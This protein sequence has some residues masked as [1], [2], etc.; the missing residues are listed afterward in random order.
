MTPGR[1]PSTST[2]ACSAEC[3][4]L[5][6]PVAVRG[7]VPGPLAGVDGC[8]EPGIVAHRVATGGDL[9]HVG[10]EG[11]QQRGRGGPGRQML[12]SSTRKPERSAV[13]AVI[14][15]R[16]L[17]SRPRLTLSG[18]GFLL[19]HRGHGS[20]GP[21]GLQRLAS[22]RPSARAVHDRRHHLRAALGPVPPVSGGRDLD[23]PAPRPLPRHDALLATRRSRCRPSPSPWP[24]GCMR[25]TASS[26][27]AG[28]CCRALSTWR[29]AGPPACRRLRGRRAVPALARCRTS[30]WARRSTGTPVDQAGVAGAWQFVDP[31]NDRFV[32]V[33]FVDVTSGMPQ[34]RW[35]RRWWKTGPPEWAG[36]LERVDAFRWDWFATLTPQ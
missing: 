22:A 35:D 10:P 25:R 33:A 9:E 23:Q 8:E 1:N 17:H 2:S 20:L 5:C 12:R 24:S 36:P 7:R 11:H 4:C 6:P 31:S 27:H 34:P 21:R 30:W 13:A 3:Q 14:G 18:A 32:T 15:R 16:V 26:R 19:L 29:V 28:H